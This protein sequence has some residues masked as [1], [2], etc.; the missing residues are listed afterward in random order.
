MHTL[1]HIQIKCLLN[2]WRSSCTWTNTNIIVTVKQSTGENFKY[3]PC[4]YWLQWLF[5]L[6]FS[7]AS[8]HFHSISN[9]IASQD[10]RKKYSDKFVAH[11]EGLRTQTYTQQATQ[12]EMRRKI[13]TRRML[14]QQ[15]NIFNKPTP[16]NQTQSQ[17]FDSI[18]F[19]CILVFSLFIHSN[20]FW[21]LLL[22]MSY[23]LPTIL[24][25]FKVVH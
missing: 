12:R 23:I 19:S 11:E 1:P 4:I 9:H 5:C 20:G 13:S 25:E 18:L 7:C 6:Q 15:V 16:L 3:R 24:N 21:L 8:F 17:T 10:L 2:C 14:W 22:N